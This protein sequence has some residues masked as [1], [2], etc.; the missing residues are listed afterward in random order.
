MMVPSPPETLSKKPSAALDARVI[1]RQ[2]SNHAPSING[3]HIKRIDMRKLQNVLH[4]PETG[5]SISFDSRGSPHR[6]EREA[7]CKGSS[8]LILRKS[9]SS[10]CKPCSYHCSCYTEKDPCQREGLQGPTLQ[11]AWITSSS[12]PST[13]RSKQQTSQH[14]PMSQLKR[15]NNT[16]TQ[17][18]KKSKTS[19]RLP[20]T[21][22]KLTEITPNAT[23]AREQQTPSTQGIADIE[24][25]GDK[26][27]VNHNISPENPMQ[28]GHKITPP[29]RQV[30]L[31][32]GEMHIPVH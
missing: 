21:V 4:T 8:S 23:P 5:Q 20:G 14:T 15:T 25:S 22:T 11:N 31:V 9:G 2:R 18:N 29:E 32:L 6:F 10:P 27:Q 3:Q 13:L 30:S 17:S 1:A 7:Q 12:P 28:S 26:K 16:S 19:T 24:D